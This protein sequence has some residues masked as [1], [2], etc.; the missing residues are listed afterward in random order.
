MRRLVEKLDFEPLFASFVNG[1]FVACT[2]EFVCVERE[3]AKAKVRCAATG[4]RHLYTACGQVLQVWTL[5]PLACVRREDMGT[6]ILALKPFR[7]GVLANLGRTSVAVDAHAFADR[8]HR[9]FAVPQGRTWVVGSHFALAYQADG[10]H[11]VQLRDARSGF[12]RRFRVGAQVVHV[13]MTDTA[14]RVV[15]LSHIETF[16]LH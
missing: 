16:F 5:S 2:S 3:R 13:H 12:A 1:L 15:T 9:A 10:A 8:K 11:W 7:G 4:K 14:L 6:A